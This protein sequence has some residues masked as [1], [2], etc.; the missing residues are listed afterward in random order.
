MG[1]VPRLPGYPAGRAAR[2]REHRAMSATRDVE[3]ERWL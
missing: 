2:L 1:V 3:N